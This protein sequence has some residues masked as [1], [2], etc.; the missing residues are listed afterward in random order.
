VDKQIVRLIRRA[1]V[2]RLAQHCLHVELVDVGDRPSPM[3]YE[4]PPDLAL[5]HRGLAGLG[6]MP[7]DE[8]L[9]DSR[10]RVILL[11]QLFPLGALLLGRRAL[12]GLDQLQPL[13]RLLPRRLERQFAV[14]AERPAG[15]IIGAG[16]PGY[17][18][19]RLL[20]FF[21]HADAEPGND[22]VHHVYAGARLAVLGHADDFQ[23]LDDAIVG[24]PLRATSGQQDRCC[25]VLP[26]V[27]RRLRLA[28]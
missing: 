15:R 5:G 25:S 3:V 22:G 18:H 14:V 28:E 10:K 24:K 19:E 4:L 17:Q 23:G 16:E 26:S 1:A 11:A 21:G 13:A 12:P 8:I 20:A 6:D 9:C 7:L 27:D 2:D